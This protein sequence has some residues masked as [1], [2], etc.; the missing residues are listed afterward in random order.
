MI[1]LLPSGFCWLFA[2]KLFHA[3]PDFSNQAIILFAVLQ[4][5]MAGVF[6]LGLYLKCLLTFIL[7]PFIFIKRPDT[8]AFKVMNM[9]R[10]KMYGVKLDFLKMIIAYIPAMLLL[11]TIPFILPKAVMAASVFAEERLK[12]E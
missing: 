5:F 8:G 12:E 6:L 9:S 3:V 7:S 10:K 11:I 2:Y 1:S 4:L